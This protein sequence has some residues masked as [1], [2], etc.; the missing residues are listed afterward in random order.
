[1]KDNKIMTDYAPVNANQVAQRADSQQIP[2]DRELQDILMLASACRKRL[3]AYTDA[4]HDRKLYHS[5]EDAAQDADEHLADAITNISQFAT[6]E[7]IFRLV[8]KYE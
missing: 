5:I 2:M 6:N 8:D 7:M 4:I 1:M 3:R